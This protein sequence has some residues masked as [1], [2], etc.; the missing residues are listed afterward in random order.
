MNADPTLRRG[1]FQP[2]AREEL[3]QSRSGRYRVR[4]PDPSPGSVPSGS[5]KSPSTGRRLERHHVVGR[6]PFGRCVH[7]RQN[8]VPPYPP[9]PPTATNKQAL[10]DED[11]IS[12]A[13]TLGI[14]RRWAA[15]ALIA[16]TFAGKVR[17]DFIS[18]VRSGVN[19][20]PTFSST[21]C[22]TTAVR[23]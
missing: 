15:Q 13:A 11:L 18:G 4:R 12:Y 3:S 6:V 8:V 1:L 21:A 2:P 9:R 22:A 16:H 17:Q 23:G 7:R 20:T 19:G 10:E 5:A 14:D